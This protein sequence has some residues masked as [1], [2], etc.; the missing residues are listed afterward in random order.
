MQLHNNN[1][2]NNNNNNNNKWSVLHFAQEPSWGETLA[3]AEKQI[4][5]IN[6]RT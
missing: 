6:H 2:D 3:K 5:I 1:D 4:N